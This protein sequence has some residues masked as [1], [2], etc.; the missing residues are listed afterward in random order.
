MTTTL[1]G[2]AHSH[3]VHATRLMLEHKGIDHRVVNLLPGFHPLAVRAVGFRQGS[4]PALKL[5]GRRI[6]GTLAIAHA[7][8]RRQADPPLFP[9]DP[10]RRRAV[11]EAQRW[12]HD[13]LQPVPRRIF[14]WSLNHDA[15]VREWM[16]R[17]VVGMPAPKLAAA[18]FKPI[19]ALFARISSADADTVR[20]DL[21]RLP[22]LLDH[23]DR[24]IAEG[25]IGGPELNAADCQIL[26][27]LRLL[28][29]TEDIA[30]ALRGRPCAAAAMRVLP[31]YPGP[32]PASLPAEWLA[33]G[34]A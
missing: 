1:Y 29:G 9:A 19:G 6:Q 11:Q 13:E 26:P 33:W 16:A 17:A 31:E 14:R 28:L 3:P 30:L 8:E 22:A 20:R 5:D 27:S 25:T 12:G 32:V 10:E 15:G 34:A 2:L 7:L 18:A 23:C 24:L 21:R 4:V